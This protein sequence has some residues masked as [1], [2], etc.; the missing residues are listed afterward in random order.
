MGFLTS[1]EIKGPNGSIRKRSLLRPS[2]EDQTTSLTD[3]VIELVNHK[4]SVTI[5]PRMDLC[6]LNRTRSGVFIKFRNFNAGSSWDLITKAMWGDKNPHINV[7]LNFQLS[8]R[9]SLLN[10]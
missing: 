7:Y 3:H 2:D 8:R 10:S 1:P 9:R 4:Y 5:S 6:E